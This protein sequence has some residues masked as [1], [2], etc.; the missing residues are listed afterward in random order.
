VAGRRARRTGDAIRTLHHVRSPPPPP[1]PP[2]APPV[3]QHYPVE[4]LTKYL[5]FGPTIL[6]HISFGSPSVESSA[7]SPQRRRQDDHHRS[8]TPSAPPS[9]S[10]LVVPASTVH[11]TSRWTAAEHRLPSR[12]VPLYPRCASR[13][14]CSFGPSFKGVRAQQ[15]AAGSSTKI[16]WLDRCAPQGG[17]PP[18]YR[19]RSKGYRQSVGLGRRQL[20]RPSILTWTN[21]L[22]AS[23]AA[24]N[25]RD[26]RPRSRSGTEPT[27]L[28]PRTFF[29]G[30][31]QSAGVLIINSGRIGLAKRCRSWNRLRDRLWRVRG[32][33]TR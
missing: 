9:C 21:R 19:T 5:L 18:L 17:A 27:I 11:E 15:A 33:P 14:R 20:S 25:P 10:A 8:L 1:P 13:I 32:P 7:S 4:N 28:L 6:D 30:W 2:L 26:A 3:L 31:M 12:I 23:S 24:A 22:S 16:F 29:R